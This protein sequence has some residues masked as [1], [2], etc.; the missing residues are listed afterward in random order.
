MLLQGALMLPNAQMLIDLL[1]DNMSAR[2]TDSVWP[3]LVV[4]YEFISLH[5]RMQ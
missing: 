1:I 5:R 2:R 3:S 4:V